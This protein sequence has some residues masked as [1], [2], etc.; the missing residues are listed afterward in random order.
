MRRVPRWNSPTCTSIL[1]KYGR[2]SRAREWVLRALYAG[3]ID[4]EP[5]TDPLVQLLEHDPPG[6]I[7]SAFAQ[8]LYDLVREHREAHER[9][10]AA[11]LENW[12]LPRV[13][14][15]DQLL[16]RIALVEFDFFPDI[17]PKVTLN[18]VI[19]LAKRY[20]SADAAGFINGVL[21]GIIKNSPESR[22]S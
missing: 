16:L 22:T 14:L 9:T 6:D 11:Q 15:I 4:T 12:D 13:A 19:E 8:R 1:A 10:L 7:D 21:D 18:E 3:A 17:P 2:R 5:E 20:S